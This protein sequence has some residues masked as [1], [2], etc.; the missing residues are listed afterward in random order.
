M[1]RKDVSGNFLEEKHLKLSLQGIAWVIKSAAGSRNIAK[2][3]LTT[4]LR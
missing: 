1:R 3:S 2:I 4:V